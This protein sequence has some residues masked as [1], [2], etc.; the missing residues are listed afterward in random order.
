MEKQKHEN[1]F[2]K[3]AISK[4]HIWH[5]CRVCSRKLKFSDSFDFEILVLKEASKV[6]TIMKRSHSSDKDDDRLSVDSKKSKNEPVLPNDNY[7][8]IRKGRST[9]NASSTSLDSLRSE[10]KFKEADRRSTSSLFDK[11]DRFVP[12]DKK[13]RIHDKKDRFSFEKPSDRS[14][15]RASSFEKS[16][17]KSKSTSALNQ[18]DRFTGSQGYHNIKLP[19]NYKPDDVGPQFESDKNKPSSGDRVTRGAGAQSNDSLKDEF[20]SLARSKHLNYKLE[21]LAKLTVNGKSIE[22]TGCESAEEAE[23]QIL[24]RAIKELRNVPASVSADE[25]M[26]EESTESELVQEIKQ[27]SLRFIAKRCFC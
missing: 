8:V 19:A 11:R 15:D 3:I 13:D 12:F 20:H 17:F 4:I 25:S 1:F 6:A 24:L 7:Y 10:S 23:K 14:S 22:S 27:V 18:P 2:L 5:I 16:S 26:S 9:T 21:Y